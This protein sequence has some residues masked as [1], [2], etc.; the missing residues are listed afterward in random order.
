[1]NT[2]F[3]TQQAVWTWRVYDRKDL[4]IGIKGFSANFLEN[5]SLADSAW[6]CPS[7]LW[8]ARSFVSWNNKNFVNPRFKGTVSRDGFGCWCHVW[9]VF[10]LNR[11]RGHFKI[12]LLYNATSLFL[13]VSASL[14]WLNTVRG[15]YLVKISFL[16]IGWQGLE[17]LFLVSAHASH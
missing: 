8:F 9:L 17:R 16:L 14:R 11:G 13:T 2:Q 12:F 4:P 10:A 7:F 15:V 6:G 1:M 5:L 3:L